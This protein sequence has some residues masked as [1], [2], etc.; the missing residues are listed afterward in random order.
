MV[1]VKTD[2]KSKVEKELEKLDKDQLLKIIK[3]YKKHIDDIEEYK[4][5]RI[6]RIQLQIEF[7]LN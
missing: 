3:I 6:I 5:K 2:F 1:D 7:C 4:K